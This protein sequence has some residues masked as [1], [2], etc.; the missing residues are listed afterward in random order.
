[1]VARRRVWSRLPAGIALVLCGCAG[2]VDDASMPPPP[3]A[4]ADAFVAG[5]VRSDG[6]VVPFAEYA[7]GTWKGPESVA[8]AGTLEGDAVQAEPWFAGRVGELRRWQVVAPLRP[9]ATRTDPRIANTTGPP[10]SVGDHCLRTWALASDLPGTPTPARV[11]H[12]NAAAAFSSDVRSRVVAELAPNAPERALALAVLL[13]VFDAAERQAADARNSAT[14]VAPLVVGAGHASTSLTLTSLYRAGGRD[15]WSVY[16]FEGTR[17]YPAATRD[18]ACSRASVMTG[19]IAESPAGELRV[20]SS[21]VQ[22]T[23]CDRKGSPIVYPMAG[24]E[25]DGRTF[26]LV[27]ELEYES[28]AYAVVE[29]APDGIREVLKVFAGGC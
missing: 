25:V 3:A 4:S 7:G 14:T 18:P 2:A 11:V 10:V 20:L 29:I 21:D 9:T 5:I 6:H 19:W 8:D 16:L 17:S 27:V 22:L 23:D 12:T 26:V 24:V 15:G 13:P 1:M 28:E